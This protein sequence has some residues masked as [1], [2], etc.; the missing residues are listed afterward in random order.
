MLKVRR[1][2]MVGDTVKF[3]TTV[4]IPLTNLRQRELHMLVLIA[5]DGRVASTSVIEPNNLKHPDVASVYLTELVNEL[6]RHK[7]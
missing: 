3:A 6:A 1:S 5:P 7:Q 4:V 2:Y